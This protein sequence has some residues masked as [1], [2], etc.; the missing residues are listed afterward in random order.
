MLAIVAPPPLQSALSNILPSAI[1]RQLASRALQHSS[2]DVR[3]ACT[4]QLTASLTKLAHV[5]D[6]AEGIAERLRSSESPQAAVAEQ[7]WSNWV[8]SLCHGV[9]YRLPDVHTAIVVHQNIAQHDEDDAVT[10]E[11]M[12]LASLG[13][14]RSFKRLFPEL[15]NE[16]HF[17]FGKLVP[18]SL[19]EEPTQVQLATIALLRETPDFKIFSKYREFA[20]PRSVL[21]CAPDQSA[22]KADKSHFVTLLKLA[23][24]SE[25]G[26]IRKE[27]LSAL[28]ALLSRVFPLQDNEGSLDVL[29]GAVLEFGPECST[30]LVEYLETAF[31]ECLRNSIVISD[32]IVRIVR[33]C[34]TL[35][36]QA[37][38]SADAG[39]GDAMDVDQDQ[40]LS[41][42]ASDRLSL[43]RRF[44]KASA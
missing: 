1:S 11:D 6:V 43:S 21:L 4:S 27:T 5:L 10:L 7:M 15:W 24:Q 23:I 20:A 8:V 39:A 44:C 37:D 36:E 41:S 12:Q 38:A 30:A 42:P 31:N 26:D 40:K 18:P 16:S 14:I 25:S 9:R 33:T 29:I 17:D 3:F 32:T 35:S 19:G 13:F 34:S 2:R 22:A 28:R